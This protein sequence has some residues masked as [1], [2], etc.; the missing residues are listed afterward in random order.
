MYNGQISPYPYSTKITDCF[1]EPEPM[2][3]FLRNGFHLVDLTV[4]PDEVI[5]QHHKAALMELLEKH[6]RLKDILPVITF[7]KQH[8]LLLKVLNQ[9]GNYVEFVLKY[10]LD[11]N[12]SSNPEQV[13]T[14]FI[15]QIPTKRS[16]IMTIADGLIQKGVQ[17]GMQQGVQQE[18]V[19]IAHNLLREGI[20]VHL[21]AK[22]TGLTEEDIIMLQ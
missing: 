17:Q 9:P 7:I 1:T 15:E 13:V 4:T 5:A 20:D 2:K 14:N 21:I 22:T 11:K 3:I 19:C 18:K 16:D 8:Q 10:V 6:I 12:E